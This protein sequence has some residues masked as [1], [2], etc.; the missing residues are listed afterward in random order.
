[1]D[2]MSGPSL[3]MKLLLDAGGSDAAID[4]PRWDR[5]RRELWYA[6]KICKRF[7]QPSDNQQ[8]LLDAFEEA[9]WPARM[10]NPLVP[11][12]T[13]NDH[14]RLADT[15]RRMNGNTAIEFE[16]D[17]TSEAVLWKPRTG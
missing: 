10:E 2:A 14:Q 15:V 8:H 16:R 3:I 7:R 5:E 11:D 12:G 9:G 1:G 4:K 6:G 17:G 13:G